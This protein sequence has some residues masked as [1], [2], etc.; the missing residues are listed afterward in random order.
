MTDP[1]MRIPK[2][3]VQWVAVHACPPITKPNKVA[4]ETRQKK[5]I[6]VTVVHFYVCLYVDTEK[7]TFRLCCT[8]KSTKCC[9]SFFHD[10]TNGEI[11]CKPFHTLNS[12]RMAWHQRTIANILRYILAPIQASKLDRYRSLIHRLYCRQVGR[13]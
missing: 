6:A 8:I 9:P 2:D 4:G 12:M 11:Q 5:T 13:N 10:L 1:C 7:L 3:P